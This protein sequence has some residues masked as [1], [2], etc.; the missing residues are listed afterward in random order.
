MEDPVFGG[1]LEFPLV[2]VSG[3]AA[4]RFL[5]GIKVAVEQFVKIVLV[6]QI[7]V[8]NLNMFDGT[9]QK[10][11]QQLLFIFLSGNK[12]KVLNTRWHSGNECGSVGD[13]S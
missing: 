9:V 2:E 6:E 13:T 5:S 4:L 12:T 8:F 3:S 7:Y 1:D 10:Q 11:D